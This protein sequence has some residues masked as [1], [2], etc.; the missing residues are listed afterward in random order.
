MRLFIAIEV[1]AEIKRDMAEVQQ[2][3]ISTG[4]VDASW[5][6]PDSIHL[7][8]KF[9]GEVTEAKAPAIMAAL[10]TA[11]IGSSRFRLGLEQVGTFPEPKRARVVWIGLHGEVEKL[12]RLQTLVEENLVS[13]GFERE[14]RTYTP[15]LTLGRIRNIRSRENWVKALTAEKDVRLQAFEVREICLMQSDLRPS[16]AVYSRLG[17]VALN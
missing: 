12:L 17:S 4:A 5:T 13:A 16:G 14:G 7:T 2:R 11:A 9:L 10:K 8:L 3:L 1:P 6:R 15:H